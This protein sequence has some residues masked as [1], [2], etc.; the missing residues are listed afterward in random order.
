MP[1]VV[2]SDSQ[3]LV[4]SSGSGV[5]IESS[6]RVAQLPTATVSAQTSAATLSAPGVYTLSGSTALTW[7]LPLAANVP[8][9]VFVFRSASAHAHALTGSQESNGT[10]VFAGHVGATPENQGS[11]LALAA[12]QGSSVALVS[13][14]LSF[15]VMAA[16]GSCVISG[17]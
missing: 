17:T 13:D 10:K 4:Q 12:V 16:S 9:G 11:K 6:L 1:K 2:I 14:G 7:V 3:G 5:E 15:L 8:G